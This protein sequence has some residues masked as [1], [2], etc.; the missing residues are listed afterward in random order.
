MLSIDEFL[1]VMKSDNIS[2]KAITNARIT[3]TQ[4]NEFKTL[5]EVTK[6]DI[7]DF[8]NYIREKYNYKESTIG[9]RKSY[10]KKYF[11]YNDMDHIVK[12]VKVPTH[13]KNLGPAEILTIQDI[14]LM[15]ENTRSPM[16]KALVTLLWESGARI[17]E[18][19][20]IDMDKD[21][22]ENTLGYELTLYGDKTRKHNYAYRKM[23]LVDAAPYLREWIALH[24]KPTTKLFPIWD[25][26][27][28]HYCYTMKRELKE[29]HGFNKP[30]SPHSFRH[31]CATRL[32][33]EGLQESLI[34]KRMGWTADSKM[35]GTYIHLADN[36]VI[37]DQINKINGEADT[38]KK[39]ELIKP[40]ESLIDKYQA[41][42]AELAEMK[43]K[44]DNIDNL[45]NHKIA[46]ILKERFEK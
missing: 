21:L 31:G 19:L 42:A 40:G 5:E 2:G 33:R 14:N 20:N 12:K 29:K 32:V 38:K 44:M 6:S 10:I 11:K 22:V 41:Q 43:E 7:V 35:I 23:L 30:L 4:L 13:H 15:I 24:T 36:A 25:T 16:Y 39:I 17:N 46:E 9:V 28:R 3:L 26:A 18:A 37:D 1:N 45:V 27:V 34:R 8:I